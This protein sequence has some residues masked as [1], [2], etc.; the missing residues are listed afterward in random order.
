[1][2]AHGLAQNER[3]GSRIIHTQKQG[4]KDKA[5]EAPARLQKKK[6]KKRKEKKRIKE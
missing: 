5:R 2:Q 1:M 4:S 3:A 6:R